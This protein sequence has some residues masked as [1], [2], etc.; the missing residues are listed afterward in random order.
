M[1][2][3]TGPMVAVYLDKGSVET[4]RKEFPGTAPGRLRKVVVQYNPS[5]EERQEYQP[6]FGGLATVKV[7]GR[8]G[9]REHVCMCGHHI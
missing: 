9:E 3:R 5:H 1:P 6:H 4:L 7:G 2:K 8:K